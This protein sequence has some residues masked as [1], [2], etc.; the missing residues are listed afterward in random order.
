MNQYLKLFLKSGAVHREI[1]VIVYL[2]NDRKQFLLEN[3]F[4]PAY[5]IMFPQRKMIP[6][7]V[8]LCISKLNYCCVKKGN[9]LD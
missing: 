6:T 3:L 9:K 2:I 8:V 5:T 4:G 1:S 7:A